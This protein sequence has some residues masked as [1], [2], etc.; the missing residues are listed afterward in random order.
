MFNSF[1]FDVGKEI[2]IKK[3]AKSKHFSALPRENNFAFSRI[4]DKLYFIV[5]KDGRVRITYPDG[6]LDSLKVS[7]SESAVKIAS[8][9]KELSLKSGVKFDVQSVISKGK[10]E[11]C[12]HEL[13]CEQVKSDSI[14]VSIFREINLFSL[15]KLFGEYNAERLHTFAGDKFGR[16]ISANNK[17]K[18]EEG[19]KKFIEDNNL[20]EVEILK[21][22]KDDTGKVPYSSFRVYKSKFVYGL[23]PTGKGECFFIQALIR[24]AFARYLKQENINVVETR[25]W[26][27]GDVFCE[28]N[29][30]LLNIS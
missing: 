3:L 13:H 28:F 30:Y 5:F 8:L 11:D 22:E 14:P 23:P 25:C 21:P 27:K 15:A 18:V 2:D 12:E 10:V 26:R 16:M 6:D 29:V 24:G 20:G 1:I 17:N 9:F 4:D 19:I 7:L